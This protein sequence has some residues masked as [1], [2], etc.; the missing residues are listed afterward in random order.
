MVNDLF[1]GRHKY[2]MKQI[3]PPRDSEEWGNPEGAEDE[4]S[5]CHF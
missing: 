5:E 1:F 4:A 3:Q 2:I